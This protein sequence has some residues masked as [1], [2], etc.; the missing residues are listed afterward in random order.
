MRRRQAGLQRRMPAEVLAQ[1]LAAVDL[2]PAKAAAKFVLTHKTT[3][4]V[5]GSVLLLVLLKYSSYLTRVSRRLLRSFNPSPQDALSGDYPQGDEAEEA[6][7]SSPSAAGAGAAAAGDDGQTPVGTP[8]GDASGVAVG[9]AG[10]GGPRELM[11]RAQSEPTL[12][13]AA[14]AGGGGRPGLSAPAAAVAA[15]QRAEV[16]RFMRL[17]RFV[18]GLPSEAI[19]SMYAR[20][21]RIR[22]SPG[23]ILFREGD[24]ALDGM[25]VIVSGELGMA[26]SHRSPSAGPGQPGGGGGGNG[27]GGGLAPYRH[28]SGWPTGHGQAAGSFIGAGSGSGSPAAAGAWPG[29]PDAATHRSAASAASSGFLSAAAGGSVGGGRGAGAGGEEESFLLLCTFS[30]GQTVGENALLASTALAAPDGLHTAAGA[31]AAAAAAQP[32]AAATTAAS[33]GV[34][35]CRLPMDCTRPVACV[36]TRE[37]VVLRLDVRVFRAFAD[38]FPHAMT[39]FILT[40]TAR[41]WR[42]A[43]FLLVDFFRLRDAWLASLEAP[44]H[45]PAFHFLEGPA[46]AAVAA[47][48]GVGMG[49]GTGLGGVVGG[50]F[51][52]PSDGSAASGSAHEASPAADSGSEAAGAAGASGVSGDAAAA[53]A[54]SAAAT[55]AAAA[56]VQY[57]EYLRYSPALPTCLRT[58]RSSCSAVLLKQPGEAVYVEGADADAVFVVLSGEGVCTVSERPAMTGPLIF[59]TQG[60]DVADGAAAEDAAHR[61]DAGAGSAQHHQQQQSQVHPLPF[62]AEALPH[63]GSP[64]GAFAGAGAGAGS[65]TSGSASGNSGGAAAFPAA[66]GYIVR[67]VGPGCIAGGQACFVGLPHRDTLTAVSLME[68]AV[69]P[70]QLFTLLASNQLP[71]WHAPTRTAAL[72]AVALAVA[73]SLVPLLR[74]FLGLGLQRLW[75]KAG[76]VLYR[77]GDAASDGL[78]VVI[79]GRM[80]TFLPLG[81]RASG[82]VGPTVAQRAGVLADGRLPSEAAGTD[83]ATGAVGLA[84]SDDDDDEDD[85]EEDGGS[86]FEEGALGSDGLSP[87]LEE[88]G[89]HAGSHGEEEDGEG[90]RY[91]RVSRLI[92]RR[93][94]ATIIRGRSRQLQQQLPHHA[95]RGSFQSPHEAQ[96]SAAASA[97]APAA[98]GAPGAAAGS[99]ARGGSSGA[100]AAAAGQPRMASGAAPGEESFAEGIYG[101]STLPSFVSA[102]SSAGGA[103]G[104][105]GGGVGGGAMGDTGGAFGG[106]AIRRVGSGLVE[107][108]SSSSSNLAATAT[109]IGASP[110]QLQQQGLGGASPA[111]GSRAAAPALS[112]RG[113]SAPV[114]TGAVRLLA[115]VN[116]ATPGAAA[117]APLLGGL[118]SDRSSGSGSDAPTPLFEFGAPPGG[119]RRVATE[120]IGSPSAAVAGAGL[121]GAACL[122]VDGTTPVGGSPGATTAGLRGAASAAATAAAAAARSGPVFSR[123]LDVGRREMIGEMSVLLQERRR[124]DTAVCVRD[125]EL[126]RIS[127]ASFDLISSRYPAVARH[128]TQALARRYQEVAGRSDSHRTTLQQLP[129]PLHP[130]GLGAGSAAGLNGVGGGSPMPASGMG[131]GHAQGALPAAGGQGLGCG[132]H[133]PG[134]ASVTALVAAALS[135]GA[136]AAVAAAGLHNHHNSS[137]HGQHHGVGQHPASPIRNGQHGAGAGAGG[138]GSVGKLGSGARGAGARGGAFAGA[139]ALDAAGASASGAG[140]AGRRGGPAQPYP[141]LLGVGAGAGSGAG[142]G[143]PGAGTGAGAGVPRIDDDVLQELA[144]AMTAG[145]SISTLRLPSSKGAAPV[146]TIAIVGASAVS[147]PVSDFSGKLVAALERMEEGP[148]LHLTAG[149]LDGL[150]GEGTCAHLDDLIVRARVGAWLSVQEERHRFIVLETETPHAGAGGAGAAVM[151]R[152]ARLLSANGGGN[153][154]AGG[155]S[156]EERDGQNSRAGGGSS[157]LRASA[158]VLDLAT[159]GVATIGRG[160]GRGIGSALRAGLGVSLGEGAGGRG[161]SRGSSMGAGGGAAAAPPRVS[162]F[163]SELC[164]QQADLC[165]LVGQAHTPADLSPVEAECVYKPAPAPAP[166]PAQGSRGGAAGFFTGSAGEAGTPW[167][168]DGGSGNGGSYSGSGGGGAGTPSQQHQRGAL[169]RTFASITRRRTALPNNPFS[170]AADLLAVQPS[171]TDYAALS[172]GGPRQ[173]VLEAAQLRQQREDALAAAAAAGGASHGAAGVR[174]P[175]VRG[176][177]GGGSGGGAANGAGAAGDRPAIANRTFATKEL[178]LLHP[179]PSRRPAGT[180]D[181]LRRRRVTW[182][183]HI[184]TVYDSD[185]DRLARHVCGKARGLVLG[186]GGS[187][188][189]AHLGVLQVLEDRGVGIDVIGGCSQGAFMAACYALTLDTKSCIP[190]A[191]RLAETIGNTW[192]LLTG[193]T[194]PIMSYFSGAAFNDALIDCFKD[195]Q[196]EDLWIRY[197]CVSTDV[198]NDRCVTHQTG[199]LWRYCRASMTVL[200]LLPPLVDSHRFLIDGGYCNNLPVDVMKS[201]APRVNQVIAVDVENKDSSLFENIPDYGDTLS[202]FYIAWK[203]FLSLLRLAPPLKIPPLSEVTLK[204]SYISH[205]MQMRQL[206]LNADDSILYI[207]PDVNRY[208]LLDYHLLPSIVECGM[209]AARDILDRWDGRQRQRVYKQLRR[210]ARHYVHAAQAA[211]ARGGAGRT[212][213]VQRRLLTNIGADTPTMFAVAPGGERPGYWSVRAHSGGGNAGTGAPRAGV[214]RVPPALLD[215]APAPAGAAGAGAG[216]SFGARARPVPRDASDGGKA[217]S[218]SGGTHAAAAAAKGGLSLLTAM[219]GLQSSSGGAAGAPTTAPQGSE[220][221][222]ARPASVGPSSMLQSD[223]RLSAST[224]DRA[225]ARHRSAGTDSL[226]GS[227]AASPLAQRYGLLPG[228]PAGVLAG[229]AGGHGPSLSMS[230]AYRGQLLVPPASPHLGAGVGGGGGYGLVAPR[231]PQLGSMPLPHAAQLGAMALSGVLERGAAGAAAAAG[232][233]AG[234]GPASAEHD[235][236]EI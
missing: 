181:W 68:V 3:T 174:S 156:D 191:K 122:A 58:F 67:R 136:A 52:V 103:P 21:E 20:L 177:G 46:A 192:N 44:A 97:A 149:R 78:Y 105:G 176:N 199:P 108:V 179:D 208:K 57:P 91:T 95:G 212:G 50:A 9:G 39:S 23:D 61:A 154:G 116:P 139:M 165:L 231:T 81:G 137:A 12:A 33:G 236:P 214:L 87:V 132:V 184:R 15:A 145:E 178:V 144:G 96:R 203:W 146:I 94:R 220:G 201:L 235:V 147:A 186:G 31:A 80:R 169:S 40:T 230:A 115:A 86:C 63:L 121:G 22:L 92:R 166:A 88:A 187:R 130:I 128:F 83:A 148:V 16:E 195:T 150:L 74:M 229:G 11:I 224:P 62:P 223:A 140:S 93:G 173:R 155:Y 77:A 167:G 162:S 118:P 221:P 55:A 45:A 90:L 228:A 206:L 48:G 26:L 158:T 70:R 24:A 79:S 152:I 56:G 106:E 226:P 157:L 190:L 215:S 60:V 111:R 143:M 53:D 73:R 30:K 200:G 127:Q 207:R 163:W 183:H 99:A 153:G 18:Q 17:M 209:M 232:S 27:G 8:A 69:F 202:G 126:I 120:V 34:G 38:S 25:Y 65:R 84:E 19:M 32:S 64:L 119:R 131:L 75:L 2:E 219:N 41:Q 185:F 113:A 213:A 141:V 138:G 142:A 196:I 225:A 82:K 217:G 112:L 104:G 37:S 13:S 151:G 109:A 123:G 28:Q 10:A 198:A 175:D 211:L 43:Y 205:S 210:A 218:G 7:L 29:A 54:A 110:Q 194:L 101:L 216:A 42:V 85:D 72:A 134:G 35:S 159:S 76:E 189:L 49:G 59:S 51:S 1:T 168:R 164:V 227:G 114:A 161:R 125:C 170:S 36:A 102:A 124:A 129:N 14:G 89:G 133:L 160:I 107:D 233:A 71:E 197:F 117:P 172:R 100:A 4:Y 180:R 182:H 222:S 135:G 204:V 188:G 5:A 171:A 66:R 98:G 6:A 193:L 47:A 234:S